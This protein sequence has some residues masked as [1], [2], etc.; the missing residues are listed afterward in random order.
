MLGNYPAGSDVDSNRLDRL[1]RIKASNVRTQRIAPTVTAE[2][3]KMVVWSLRLLKSPNWAPPNKN[4]DGGL[5]H[6][7]RDRN[8]GS[9]GKM[10]IAVDWIRAS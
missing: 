4:S 3:M 10:A 5:C 9:A 7:H 6:V 1:G 2:N 8:S